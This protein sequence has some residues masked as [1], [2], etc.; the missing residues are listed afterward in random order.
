MK[1]ALTIVFLLLSTYI[2][3]TFAYAYPP[4]EVCCTFGLMPITISNFRYNPTTHHVTF[5]TSAPFNY[6]SPF[7]LNWFYSPSDTYIGSQGLLGDRLGYYEGDLVDWNATH[8]ELDLTGTDIGTGGFDMGSYTDNVYLITN[9]A[10]GNFIEYYSNRFNVII[11]TTTPP[12]LN[13]IGNKTVN[14]GE[15]LQFTITAS[16]P[17]NDTLTYS[18]A[19][20][21]PGASFNAQTRTFSWTPTFNQEGNYENIEFTVTNNGTPIELDTELI[22][23]NVGN[24][25]RAPEFDTVSPKEILENVQLNFSVQATDPDGDEFTLSA[26]DI[27]SG[28]SFNAQSGVFSWTPTLSQSGNYIVTFNATDNGTPVEIGTIDVIITV[29]D[30][31]TPIEQSEDLNTDVIDYSL[32]TNVENSYL[33]NLKKVT[34]FIVNGQMQAAINQLNAFI[35]KVEQDYSAGKITQIVRNDLVGKAQALLTDLQS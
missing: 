6:T 16:D 30:E 33:S 13:P 31:P 7:Q 24:V 5:D 20:L 26:S 27:P 3:P 35:S 29:G 2:F 32:P 19:N 10:G 14:E 22:T 18:A 28:A 9:N 1:R 21:P 4:K 11:S 23:I 34:I 25:N 17:D 15:Q 12:F 8:F